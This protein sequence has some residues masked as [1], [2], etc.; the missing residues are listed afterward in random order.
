MRARE[1]CAARVREEK[2][3]DTR[4]ARANKGNRIA[5]GVLIAVVSLFCFLSD[6]GA[7]GGVG[8]MVYG[9]LVGFFGLASYAYALM[10]I[11]FGIAIAFGVKIR[12]RLARSAYLFGMLL[13]GIL[14][15]H[16]YTSSGHIIGANYGEYL[17]RCY[18]ETNTAG[19]ML[20]GL[21]A[22]PL[23]KVV[24]GVG[25]LSIACAAFLIM[26]GCGLIPSLRRNVVY[27]AATPKE[28]KEESEKEK[29]PRK[30]RKRKGDKVTAVDEPVITDFSHTSNGTRLF[31]VDVEGKPEKP[32]K[33]KGSYGYVPLG[34]DPLYPNRDGGYEDEQRMTASSPYTAP[35][36]ER[37]TYAP[38]KDTARE[39]LFGSGP[40]DENIARYEAAR[41]GRMEPM[42]DVGRTYSTP[43]QRRQDMMDTLG[44]GGDPQSE[45]IAR[46]RAENEDRAVSPSGEVDFETLK[47]E[48]LRQW[49]TSP[50][51]IFEADASSAPSGREV[52]R[53]APAEEEKKEV[54]RPTRHMPKAED[55]AASHPQDRPSTE[56]VNV[57][58]LGALNMAKTNQRPAEPVEEEDKETVVDAYR[59]PQSSTPGA[60]IARSDGQSGY[61][62]V[63][64]Q[65]LDSV[66]YM[67]STGTKLPRAFQSS[68]V[69]QT[70][71]RPAGP[72][73]PA[74][75]AYQPPEKLTYQ[76]VKKVEP[77]EPTPVKPLEEEKP[78]EEAQIPSEPIKAPREVTGDKMSAS[79]IQSATDI[80]H[81]SA[82][83]V[84]SAEMDARIEN[85][86][87]SKGLTPAFADEPSMKEKKAK[88]ASRRAAAPVEEGAHVHQP[89]VEQVIKKAEAPV[90]PK[91]PYVA[92]PLSL[93]EP[94][95]EKLAP[96][97]DIEEKKERLVSTLMDF[98]IIGDVESV[99][100]GPTFTMYRVKVTLK[101]GISVATILK[102]SKDIAMKMEVESVR[103]L[104]PIPGKNAVGIE[105]PNKRRRTVNISEILQSSTFNS[106]SD[107]AT[108]ALGVDLYGNSHVARVTKLPHLLVAGT[109]GSGKSCCINTLIVSLL[110]KASP[111]DIRFILVDPKRVELSVYAGIPHLLMDEIICDVDKAIKALAWAEK[112][113]E[114]RTRYFSETGYRDIAEYNS[115]VKNSGLE[116]MPLILIIIDEFADLMT[117]GKKAVEV[118]VGRI[119]SLAR[120]VG[121]HLVLATQRPSVDVISGTIRNN[122]PSR[123]AFRVSDSGSSRTIL[124]TVGAEDLLGLGDMLYMEPGTSDLKRIQGAFISNPEVKKVVEFVKS[125]NDCY[126]D[127]QAKD[128]IFNDKPEKKPEAAQKE[129]KAT[130]DAPD[131]I[132]A[133]ELGIL[134]RE[135]DG[136]SFSTSYIQ[137]KLGF[138][139]QKAAR[140]VD[141]VKD[142]GYIGVS[143]RDS[144]KTIVTMTREEFEEF[145]SSVESDDEGDDE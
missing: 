139:Y 114:R 84:E 3:T 13:L 40:S 83:E 5:I 26:A 11:I 36:P 110:Y 121:I 12:Q 8:R 22:Y 117:M 107:P 7:L 27:K 131:L 50:A 39:I 119:A 56:N 115:D 129:S 120:A 55:K 79:A 92:P 63:Q 49:R 145:K 109:T 15:L 47:N 19:G 43:A 60:E 78:V 21:L 1:R 42:S 132:A 141:T 16:I 46:H 48:S 89:T 126:F 140:I 116:K 61:T 70:P 69:D 58:M 18:H 125:H 111:D 2:V 30:K 106:A 135:T 38:M 133:L 130:R 57:G 51:P 9:F 81:M 97:D 104:A 75:P 99:D 96:D 23:M 32:R 29:A 93:L 4:Q 123:V 124:D 14:A 88:E 85:I 41:K 54:A 103:I 108:F 64:K 95:T 118:S 45:F 73:K 138:G 65:G 17:L 122:I 44:G 71:A 82:R 98:D 53:A 91:R 74:E 137:R 143:E 35:A 52:L 94:P 24:T 128:A 31:V 101:K 25:A 34:F 100:V 10:G 67:P 37:A 112:E 62:P 59:T 68:A 102:Y 66:R 127:E 20:F 87:K 136:N 90:K 113:M 6:I 28:R 144:K 80:A 77:Y 105:V 72:A 142:M 33:G 134:L 76:P 86:K